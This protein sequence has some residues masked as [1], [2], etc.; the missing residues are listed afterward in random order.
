MRFGA[1]SDC[2][3]VREINEDS[4]NI[5]SGYSDIPLCFIIADGMGGHKAGEVASSLAVNFVSENIVFKKD[6]FNDPNNTLEEIVNIINNANQKVYEKS[7]LDESNSGMGTTFILGIVI[8]KKLLIAHI[9]DSR[10][11]LIRED[12]M[13]QLTT[14][15]S[16]VE[17]M[18]QNGSMTR[19]E[20]ENH[21]KKNMITR[22]LG[23][24]PEIKVDT[25]EFDL[26]IGDIILFATD[27][28]TNLLLEEEIRNI[29]KTS[30]DPQ[31]ACN[32]LVNLANDNGGDDN[33]TTIVVKID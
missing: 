8:S 17:E 1:K 13:K 16:Y 21:P 4:Y 23:C 32:S 20:A 11:Y 10:V 27:G 33:L 3:R 12:G 18:V 6:I 15:H 28:I 19:E 29:L 26:E 14:D 7:L 31:V 5:I 9:G 25:Y 2:G 30:E 24:S 22:A